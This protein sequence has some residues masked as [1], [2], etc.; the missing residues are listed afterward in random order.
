MFLWTFDCECCRGDFGRLGH[1]HGNDI[2]VPQQIS[3]LIGKP[4]ASVSCGD[5]HTLVV[6]RDGKLMGFGRNQNGQIGNGTTADCFDC[7]EVQNLQ[8]ERIVGSSCGAEHSLCVTEGGT[9]YAWGW[10]R[11]GNLGTGSENDECV[12]TED[13]A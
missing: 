8:H 10:G 5:A 1:G 2:T 3:S 4:V 11:Y 9:V 6:L 13:W 7:V 12:L